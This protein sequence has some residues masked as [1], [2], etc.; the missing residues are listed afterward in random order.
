MEKVHGKSEERYS[1]AEFAKWYD[2][3]KEK[4]P[5]EYR[6]AILSEANAEFT[7]F[8]GRVLKTGIPNN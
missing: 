7:R 4:L 2:L 3:V 6:E 5:A 8:E 1:K